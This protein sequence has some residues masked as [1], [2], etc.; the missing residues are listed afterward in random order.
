MS[1]TLSTRYSEED[2]NAYA[3][4]RGVTPVSPNT[5]YA[6]LKAIASGLMGLR[7]E[8]RAREILKEL[9]QLQGDFGQFRDAFDLGQKH[10][11][12]AQSAFGE[13]SDRAGKLASQV[14]QFVRVGEETPKDKAVLQR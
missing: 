2:I 5:L 4:S 13:A 9:Q 14:D 11:R 12:N 1:Y 8:E 6:H 3:L 7:I 10:L